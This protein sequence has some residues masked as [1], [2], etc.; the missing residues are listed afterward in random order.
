M[1]IIIASGK[2]QGKTLLSAFDAALFDAGVSNYNLLVLSSIIPPGSVIKLQK[3]KTPDSE[4]GH[5]LYV[6]MSENR[7]RESGRYIGAAIGWC[8]EE[9]GRGVFVEHHFTENSEEAVRNLLQEEVK[10]SLADLCRLRGYSFSPKKMNIKMSVAKV[11]DAP[12]S[13]LV[14][15]VYESQGWREQTSLV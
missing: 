14:V 2:G 15:A 12:S 4:Y 11:T 5:R 1:N 13:V 10:H 9:D 7:S 6:V 3:Y 8:Q